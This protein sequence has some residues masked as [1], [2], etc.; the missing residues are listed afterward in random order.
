M[1]QAL[2]STLV[3]SAYRGLENLTASS[4]INVLKILGF[5]V[6]ALLKVTVTFDAPGISTQLGTHQ[7]SINLD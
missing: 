1:A 6:S 5:D 3:L 4:E 2:K 7:M